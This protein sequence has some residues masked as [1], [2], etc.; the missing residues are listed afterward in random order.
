MSF[1]DP[2][3]QII[4]F[5]DTMWR[6]VPPWLKTGIAQKYLYAI[7]VQLDA[8][9]DALVAGVKMR[10]PNLYSSDSLAEIGTERRIRRGLSESDENYASRLVRWFVDH[11]VRGG[12]YALLSQLY[13]HYQPN[14][15]QI[16]LVYASG[17]RFVL[18]P[19]GTITH[20][21]I[22]TTPTTAWAHWQLLYYDAT[23]DTDDVTTIPREWIAAHCLGEIVLLGTA[24]LWNYPPERLW[25]NMNP[26]D[27]PADGGRF[28]V[29]GG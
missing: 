27:S 28:D 21:V 10:F 1:I 25:N 11:R 29:N 13:Y 12:P 5:R 7:T 16:D 8:A 18:H 15:F 14:T 4:T 20:D 26:W 3:S 6:S 23:V 22:A 19:D 17:G 2:T 24:W 9:G